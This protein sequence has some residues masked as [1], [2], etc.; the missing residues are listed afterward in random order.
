[1]FRPERQREHRFLRAL[2]PSESEGNAAAADATDGGV[3]KSQGASSGY[4]TD[5]DEDWV[6]LGADFSGYVEKV[7][8]PSSSFGAAAAPGQ[9][10]AE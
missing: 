3:S 7:D 1:M 8:N 10:R 5:E 9:N 4:K 6:V 2:P